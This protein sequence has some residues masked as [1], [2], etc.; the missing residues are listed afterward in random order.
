V[1][2]TG[3]NNFTGYDASGYMFQDITGY[4]VSGY[5]FQDIT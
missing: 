4:N 3:Y 5:M 1:A 2:I